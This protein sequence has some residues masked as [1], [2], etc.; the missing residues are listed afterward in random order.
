MHTIVCNVPASAHKCVH[1][2]SHSG[3]CEHAAAKPLPDHAYNAVCPTHHH[4]HTHAY[5]VQATQEARR[6]ECRSTCTRTQ[7][8]I[9]SLDRHDHRPSSS[10]ALYQP[11][12]A[13]QLWP[14][15]RCLPLHES[16]MHTHALYLIRPA[17]CHKQPKAGRTKLLCKEQDSTCIRPC[18][19]QIKPSLINTAYSLM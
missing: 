7:H 5:M 15:I 19:N 8:I 14:T 17:G 13:N 4:E 9:K 6:V 3:C 1:G 11:C 18:L 10:P 16:A 2:S 12:A